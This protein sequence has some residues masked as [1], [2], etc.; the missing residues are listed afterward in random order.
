M[1][2][3][4]KAEAK[5]S[6]KKDELL[7]IGPKKIKVNS[8]SEEPSVF[9]NVLKP[10]IEKTI[11]VNKTKTKNASGIEENN[12]TQTITPEIL[13]PVIQAPETIVYELTY[14]YDTEERI[15]YTKDLPLFLEKHLLSVTNAFGCSN[16][17]EVVLGRKEIKTSCNNP[18]SNPELVID[19]RSGLLIKVVPDQ[20]WMNRGYD[21]TKKLF[22]ETVLKAYRDL[23]AQG[24]TSASGTPSTEVGKQGKKKAPIQSPENEED[25][26]VGNIP[27]GRGPIMDQF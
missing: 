27:V 25:F 21:E 4:N 15:I 26:P 3:Q 12:I 6:A 24:I 2:K 23:A 18:L 7:T 17:R 10:G 1:G 13:P 14:M 16:L 5:T 22:D 19:M 20:D 11:H 8:P 9:S